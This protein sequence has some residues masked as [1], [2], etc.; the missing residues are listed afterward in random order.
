MLYSTVKAAAIDAATQLGVNVTKKVCFLFC[1]YS[2]SLLWSNY[3]LQ[4]EITDPEDLVESE[5]LNEL[6]PESRTLNTKTAFD[7]PS[8]PG[9]A[10]RAPRSRPTRK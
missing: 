10:G 3:F 8:R 9:A 6:H 4:I 5:L 2:Y 7:R 1:F